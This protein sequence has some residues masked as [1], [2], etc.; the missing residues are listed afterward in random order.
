M[1]NCILAGEV[2]DEVTLEAEHIR[3]LGR[4]T[5]DLN[6]DGGAGRHESTVTLLTM[7][8]QRVDRLTGLLTAARDQ[9]KADGRAGS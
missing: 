6:I 5:L 2:F 4:A 9:T 7:I 3:M 1:N 8:L